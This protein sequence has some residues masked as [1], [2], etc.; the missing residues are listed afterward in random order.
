MNGFSFFPNVLMAAVLSLVSL[1]GFASEPVSNSAKIRK[2]VRRSMAYPRM[3]EA[4][5][6]TEVVLV[7]FR[8]EYCGTVSVLEVNSSNAS[9]AGYVIEK[10]E[11]MRFTVSEAE[12]LHMRF[13]FRSAQR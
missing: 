2:E 7:K 1:T 3:L 4:Q 8:I 11:S 9:F 13:T 10:L 6:A 5:R 12:E